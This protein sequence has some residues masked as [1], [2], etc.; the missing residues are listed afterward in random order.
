MSEQPL[1]LVPTPECPE[2][3]D[4]TEW[5]NNISE[6]A[7]YGGA[8]PDRSR[9]QEGPMIDGELTHRFRE[10]LVQSQDLEWVAK[11]LEGLSQK[12]LWR[13]EDTGAS[14]TL[15]KFEK[16]S[17][18]PSRHSHASNQFM[19]CLSGRYTYVP[20]GITLTTGSFY[21]NPRGSLHGPTYAEEETIL[22]EFYDGPHYPTQPD[23]YSN[24]DDAR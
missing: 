14:I 10:I 18:I 6:P 11:S 17:G 7:R 12:A 15:V 19:F 16:G 8:A 4:K 13:N 22:V 23:W 3:I 1:P 21:W 2:T 9:E 24:P 5:K 20:T